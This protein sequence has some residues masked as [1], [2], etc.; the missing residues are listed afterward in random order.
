MYEFLHFTLLVATDDYQFSSPWEADSTC[1]INCNW[2]LSNLDPWSCDW[3]EQVD[4]LLFWG[5]LWPPMA[6]RL[7]PNMAVLEVH[8][9]APS[10]LVAGHWDSW[11]VQSETQMKHKRWSCIDP[12]HPLW[13]RS[14]CGIQTRGC[15]T[16]Q[17]VDPF[18][19]TDGHIIDLYNIFTKPPSTVRYSSMP[20]AVALQRDVSMAPTPPYWL[21]PWRVYHLL[22]L[23]DRG[24]LQ[25][26]HCYMDLQVAATCPLWCHTHRCME[27]TRWGTWGCHLPHTL[28]LLGS[29]PEHCM[30]QRGDLHITATALH[31]AWQ[32]LPKR[33]WHNSWLSQ[34]WILMHTHSWISYSYCI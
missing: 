17:A 18:S 16:S 5:P 26:H 25:V 21:P 2:H 23:V 29:Q 20:M 11:L 33:G 15:G 31:L 10:M 7:P 27:V 30:Y 1:A 9:E 28:Y 22:P 24:I 32:R 34:L 19:S 12:H 14:H 8:R 6:K 4:C 3:K 13:N